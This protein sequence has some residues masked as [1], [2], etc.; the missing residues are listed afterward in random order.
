M[1]SPKEFWL[2]QK[3]HELDSHKLSVKD[4]KFYGKKV[5]EVRKQFV[6]HAMAISNQHSENLVSS[7]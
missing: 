5:T 7:L 4:L 2:A 1:F 6:D 3:D